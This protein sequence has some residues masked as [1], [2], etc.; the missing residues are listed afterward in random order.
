MG[1]NTFDTSDFIRLKNYVMQGGTLVLTAAHIN[2]NLQPDE[3]PAFPND[4]DVIRQLL[5]QDYRSLTSK[6]ER[7]LGLGRV[8]YFPQKLYPAD[9]QIRADYE[10]TLRNISHQL[11]AEQD[12]KGWIQTPPDSKVSWTAWEHGDMRVIYLLNIDWERNVAAR[13]LNLVQS[14]AIHH[15]VLYHRERCRAPRL[16]RDG[17]AIEEATHI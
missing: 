9:V 5:G 1:W 8:I 7:T 3:Q 12:L 11:S 16:H 6:T 15:Q 13:L 17:L 4:D 10:Q 2:S 14:V